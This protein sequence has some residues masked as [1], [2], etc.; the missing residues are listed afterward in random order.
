M[1]ALSSLQGVG[2]PVWG[3]AGVPAVHTLLLW[4]MLAGRTEQQ[5]CRRRPGSCGECC[6]ANLPPIAAGPGVRATGGGCAGVVAG[7]C[8]AGMAAAG[9]LI[10][11]ISSCRTS[12]RERS[13][14]PPRAPL[15]SMLSLGSLDE[16]SSSSGSSLYSFPEPWP[17]A[18]AELAA[19]APRAAPEP[20]EPQPEPGPQQ[21]PE[22]EPEEEL[23][24]DPESEPESEAEAEAEE[25]PE[26]EL[27]PQPES[28]AASE[29]EPEE[30]PEAEPSLCPS[31]ESPALLPAAPSTPYSLRMTEQSDGAQS[32]ME[33]SPPHCSHTELIQE[34]ICAIRENHAAVERRCQLLRAVLERQ[35]AAGTPREPFHDPPAQKPPTQEPPAQEPPSLH[36]LVQI[37]VLSTGMWPLLKRATDMDMNNHKDTDMDT[38]A[39][40][41]LDTDEHPEVGADGS[42]PQD[43]D[44]SVL[45]DPGR[46][47]PMDPRR[48]IPMDPCR[49]IPADAGRTNPTGCLWGPK[50]TAHLRVTPGLC[51]ARQRLQHSFPRLWRWVQERWR[52]CRAQP[53]WQRWSSVGRKTP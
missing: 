15:A 52:H 50:G 34:L 11:S 39:D 33:P 17:G 7:G 44:Q 35:R 25:E 45:M 51:R 29:E 3:W 49:A 48:N 31:S 37:N 14:K 24:P 47:S 4:Q 2:P 13:R 28:E 46:I 8:A 42:A 43:L 22:P 40:M 32:P 1:P 20:R 38:D 53:F 9:P 41:N 21:E 6:L 30:E 27:E 36:L 18:L 19:L 10:S 5:G 23:E 26:E 16:S 12:P